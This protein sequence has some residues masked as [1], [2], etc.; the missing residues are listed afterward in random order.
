M[1]RI[2]NLRTHEFNLQQDLRELESRIEFLEGKLARLTRDNATEKDTELVRHSSQHLPDGTDPVTTAAAEA[3]DLATS[4]EGTAN[5]LARS[6]HHHQLD[7]SIAPTWTGEHTFS[8]AVHA[9]GLKSGANQGAAGAAAN[10]LWVDTSD[11]ETVKR[12]T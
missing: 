12:G 1:T 10:E 6:D 8:D 3:V 7:Q 4:D 11:G 9:G 5:S 2:K